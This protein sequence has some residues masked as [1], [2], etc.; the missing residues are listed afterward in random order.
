MHLRR[1]SAARTGSPSARYL[2]A[3][4]LGALGFLA[5]LAVVLL[6]SGPHWREG[7]YALFVVPAAL[8]AG[9]LAAGVAG[10]IAVKRSRGGAGQG[11]R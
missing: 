7:E 11:P 3:F 6:A 4:G 2:P 8:L 9:A 1:P 5:L 10:W